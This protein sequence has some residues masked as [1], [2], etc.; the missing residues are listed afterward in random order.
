MFHNILYYPL[1]LLLSSDILTIMDTTDK[2]IIAAKQLALQ[3]MITKIQSEIDKL[4]D[5]LKDDEKIPF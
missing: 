2:L 1:T 3:Q 4:E 5:E